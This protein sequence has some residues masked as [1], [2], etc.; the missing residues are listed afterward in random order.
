MRA[1]PVKDDF[2]VRI[3]GIDLSQPLDAATRDEL[4]AHWMRYKVAV[5]PGQDLSEDALANFAEQL[6]PL[7]VHVQKQLLRPDGRKEIMVL[8]NR[9][10]THAPVTSDLEWHTDQS[11]TPKPVFGTILHGL[12]VTRDGGETVFADLAGA[13]SSLPDELRD[14]VDGVT[15]VYSAEGPRVK[16]RIVLTDQQRKEIPDVTHPLI[17]HH[18]YLNRKS[19]Y[20]SPMHIR[21]IGGM[22]EEDTAALMNDLIAHATRPEHT[23]A[24]RWSVGDVVMWDNTS[25]MHRRTPFPQDQTLH[26]I[27]AGFRLP[28]ERAVPY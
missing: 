6:G 10:G 21:T 9:P 1:T 27:R 12:A 4:L 22:S 15:A 17:R 20:N 11:Y 25:V 24:H 28:E 14:R 7:F 2:V 26:L 5:F 3:E 16:A 19:L 13:F 18:P 8:S 23:Y